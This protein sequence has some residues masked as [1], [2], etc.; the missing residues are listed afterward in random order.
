MAARRDCPRSKAPAA[1]AEISLP[2]ALQEH[3]RV[4]ERSSL[5]ATPA[6]VLKGHAV[7]MSLSVEKLE[8]AVQSAMKA[9]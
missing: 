2:T 4:G 9:A 6:F 5:G 8:D 3:R 1:V 7:N